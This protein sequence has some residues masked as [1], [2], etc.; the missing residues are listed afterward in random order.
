M[1]K[2]LKVIFPSL[3]A[4]F[5]IL[6]TGCL[7]FPHTTKRSAAVSG[8]VIDARTREPIKGAKVSP[9]ISPHHATY[10]DANGRFRM[11]ATRNFHWAYVS[12]E[13]HG[14][15]P[16]DSYTE[17]SHDGYVPYGFDNN[18]DRDLGDVPLKPEP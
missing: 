4:T 8:R 6:L 18:D 17:I 7:P 3:T 2:N 12:P 11:R 9:Q 13:G 14:P 16:K 10:T 5:L 15:E 1:N